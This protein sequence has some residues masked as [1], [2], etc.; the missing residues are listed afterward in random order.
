[1]AFTFCRFNIEEAEAIPQLAERRTKI[2]VCSARRVGAYRFG[3]NMNRLALSLGFLGVLLTPSP[4]HVGETQKASAVARVEDV[5]VS[6][7][8]PSAI[9]RE[10]ETVAVWKPPAKNLSAP[11]P[12]GS[13]SEEGRLV[14]ASADPY[15][16]PIWAVVVR[17]ATLR[18]APSV[19]SPTVDYYGVGTELNIIGMDKGWFE[20]SHP[21][22]RQRGWI[23]GA[24]YLDPIAGPGARKIAAEAPPALKQA[25]L[26]ERPS[27]RATAVDHDSTQPKPYLL[28]P[29]TPDPV[30]R[31]EAKRGESVY[32][33][34]E[35]A[36]RP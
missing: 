2:C 28:A 33:L 26:A 24:H 18:A 30:V 21:E 15:V 35:R 4:L 19:S 9:R 16:E 14:E 12:S 29:A 5:R 25:A 34:M 36:L 27:G 1:M 7:S 23:L 11:L 17:G 3:C 32:E 31:V 22:T 6:S 20:V 13:P 10:R 8:W